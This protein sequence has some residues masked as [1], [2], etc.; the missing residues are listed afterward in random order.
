[1]L[2]KGTYDPKVKQAYI[3]TAIISSV[4]LGYYNV[5]HLEIIK[6]LG[7]TTFTLCCGYSLTMS[8]ANDYSKTLDQWREEEAG[9]EEKTDPPEWD[10]K[11][12]NVFEHT[13]TALWLLSALCGYIHSLEYLAQYIQL[14]AAFLQV[15]NTIVN[16]SHYRLLRSSTTFASIA[17]LDYYQHNRALELLIAGIVLEILC[18]IIGTYHDC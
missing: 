6:I 1:M 7:N 3:V 13:G 10:W 5:A 14:F 15:Y 17:I 18:E 12:I 4:A 11:I 9:Y 8:F 16:Y 2:I